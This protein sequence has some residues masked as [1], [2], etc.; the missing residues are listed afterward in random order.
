MFAGTEQTRAHTYTAAHLE[1]VGVRGAV[2][3]QHM[4]GLGVRATLDKVEATK[5][6][7]SDRQSSSR[8]TAVCK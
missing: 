4:E 8:L 1:F 3:R 7:S 6:L 5:H 2:Q